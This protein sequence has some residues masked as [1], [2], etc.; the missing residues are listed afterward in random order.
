MIPRDFDAQLEVYLLADSQ[1]QEWAETTLSLGNIHYHEEKVMV[2]GK[3]VEKEW[4]T[5]TGMVADALIDSQE[6]ILASFKG[7]DGL[8]WDATILRVQKQ[9]GETCL[10]YREPRVILEQLR[11]KV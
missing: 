7:T 3:W 11:G 10:I 2:K 4:L 1:R 5:M 8:F 6:I 9:N